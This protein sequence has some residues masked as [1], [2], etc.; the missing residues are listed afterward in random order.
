MKKYMVICA[1][2]TMFLFSTLNI[3]GQGFT[4]PSSNAAALPVMTSQPITIM[5]ARNLPQHSFVILNGNIVNALPGGKN[6]TFSDPTGEII[7]DIGS[8]HWRGLGIGVSDNVEIYSEV[9]VSKGQVTLNVQA[10]SLL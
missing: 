4:G 5:E 2:I 6:Y 1:F 8:K 7:I 10:I 3:F 9:K